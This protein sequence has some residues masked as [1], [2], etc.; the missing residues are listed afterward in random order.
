MAK[1]KSK[2]SKKDIRRIQDNFEPMLKEINGFL[3]QWLDFH[4]AYKRA[5]KGEEVTR[6][7]EGEFLSLKSQ[8]AR[9]HAKLRLRLGKDYVG[10]MSV[11]PVLTQTVTLSQ[12]SRVRPEHY[13]RIERAWHETY[14]HLNESIG[15]LRYI[16]E[17]GE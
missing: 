8:V 7:A 16:L 13:E 10:G 3:E 2:R 4:R 6:E 12:M 15:H 5:Y 1:K 9:S 11:R 14:I 17:G